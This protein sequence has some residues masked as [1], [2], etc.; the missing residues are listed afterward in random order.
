MGSVIEIVSA[1]GYLEKGDQANAR[2]MLQLSVEGNLLLVSRY[3]TP[4]L[5]W[6]V[7]GA[8]QKWF[9]QYA[10][11]RKANPLIEYPD[12]GLMRK[13]VDEVLLRHAQKPK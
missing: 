3:G 6:Y 2:K 7:P 4:V 13:K 10:R 5:D 12:D 11:M 1:L 9:Q 8:Q